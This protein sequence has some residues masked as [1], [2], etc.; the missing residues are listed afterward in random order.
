MNPQSNKSCGWGLI[1]VALG[2][3]ALFAGPRVLAMLIAAALVVWFAVAET[4]REPEKVDARDHNT[5]VRS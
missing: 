2:L 1:L 3:L 4:Y 5:K